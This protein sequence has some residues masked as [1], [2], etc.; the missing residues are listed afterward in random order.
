MSAVVLGHDFGDDYGD[1]VAAAYPLVL[2][3]NV[4]GRIEVDVDQDWFSF[5]APYS[6]NEY[7]VSVT[8]G[9]LW[10]STA[11]LA[12]PDGLSS[13][14]S[15][16][17]VAS[18]T[19]RIAW[20]HVGPPA[21]YFVRIGGFAS[22]TTGTYAIVVNKQA[23]A[24]LDHDGMPDDWE[25]AWFQSTNQPPSGDFDHDG[26]SN[27]D[28][29]LGGTNPTNSASRLQMT[30]LVAT[31]GGLSVSWAAVPFRCYAVEA[32][33]NLARGEWDYL[34]TVTNLG[35]LD[36]QRYE[37]ISGMGAARFYRVRVLY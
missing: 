3:S 35:A 9:T 2:G 34:G 18:V 33:T 7:V 37:N 21:M 28:E 16:D 29:F 11:A 15:T 8:T 10:N 6:T 30:G 26:V 14:A 31:G 5:V 36:S 4:A 13:L 25:K 20:V 23:Y 32:S 19:S 1:T 24:D 22:F 12:A 27:V 17:S